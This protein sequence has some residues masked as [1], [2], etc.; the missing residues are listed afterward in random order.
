MRDMPPRDAALTM[1][2]GIDI[3]TS[4]VKAVLIDEDGTCV[5]RRVAPLT[6]QRPSSLWSEQDPEAWWSATSSCVRDLPVQLRSDL[7]SIG[8]SGQMHGATLLGSDDAPLRPCILW[9]DGRSSLEAR[10]LERRAPGL[11]RISGNKAMAG[12]TAPKLLWVARHEPD[13]F[14]RV[15]RV[16]LPK[17]YVRLRL[18]GEYATD[19]SDASGTLWF[20]VARRQWSEELLAATGLT[21]A[22]MPR[23]V[24]G[25]AIS[26]IVRRDVG[27]ELGIPAVPVVGGGGDNAAGAVA[28]GAVEAGRA[29][30]SL[31]TSGV[32]FVATDRHRPDAE[33]GV[34]AFCHALPDRWH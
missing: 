34:H 26:G 25:N 18:T 19:P 9:N 20:D 8:L 12:F 33:H 15:S 17:D 30:I 10:E 29:L 31:G 13:V 23:V 1:H 6:V 32:Y 28:I 3:G 27:R 16:L 4:S 14:S 2:L 21:R 7:H 11:R 24:E 22:A 5:E